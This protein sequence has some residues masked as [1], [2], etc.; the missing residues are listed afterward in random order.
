MYVCLLLDG[1]AQLDLVFTI[2]KALE[3]LKLTNKHVYLNRKN[4]VE[5][6]IV[7]I[8]QLDYVPMLLT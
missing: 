2:S 6:N 1:C 8:F 4:L 3:G 7:S 5:I